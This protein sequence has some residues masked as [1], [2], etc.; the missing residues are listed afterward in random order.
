MWQSY[1]NPSV[2]RREW[3]PDEEKKLLAATQEFEMQ[4]WEEIA[5]NVPNRSAFQCFV[6]YR[7]V[8]NDHVIQ[9]TPFSRWTPNEDQQLI[10]TVEKYRIGNVIPWTKIMEKMHGRTKGQLY[11]R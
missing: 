1:L 7:T 10:Q 9:R 4:N 6:H 3:T 2:N 5:K 11:N 8:F